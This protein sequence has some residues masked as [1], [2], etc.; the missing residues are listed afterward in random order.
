MSYAGI[1]Y[2]LPYIELADGGREE[3]IRNWTTRQIGVY[4]H[5]VANDD[6]GFCLLLQCQK[7]SRAQNSI[8][9]LKCAS[10]GESGKCSRLLFDIHIAILSTYFQN[11]Q[12]YLTILNDS[13]ENTVSIM[14]NQKVHFIQRIVQ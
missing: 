6:A 9:R 4:Q 8:E 10:D 1:Q 5:Y 14:F 13:F 7:N 12:I 2:N 11:W 3:D